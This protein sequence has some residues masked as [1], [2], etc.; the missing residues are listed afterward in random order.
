[1]SFTFETTEIPGVIV[2][3]THEFIDKRGIYRKYHEKGIFYENG[4][5][6]DFNEASDLHSEKGVLRGMHYQ[7]VSSQAKLVRA[8][9]GEIFD[10]ALD[11]RR[12]SKTFGRYHTEYLQGDD[13]KEVYIPEGF[14]HGFLS[15]TDRTVFSYMCSGEYLPEYC[16]GIF[17]NDPELAI[18]WPLEEYE[19]REVIA[20]EKDLSWPVWREYCKEQKR[21][22]L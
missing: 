19:I 13:N 8:I 7:T 21:I 20:T 16:G 10:V 9:S 15:L 12:E 17:Y 11:L 2:I 18:P 6:A 3:R 22:Q 4:I 14:A 1:M 5:T